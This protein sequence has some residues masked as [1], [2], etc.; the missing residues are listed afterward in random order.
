VAF[1]VLLAGPGVRGDSLMLLQSQAARR[2]A[3]VGE[4]QLARE[5]VPYR[6]MCA[7]AVAGDSVRLASAVRALVDLQLAG[8]PGAA[9]RQGAALDRLVAS[10]VSQVSDPWTRYFLAHDPAPALRRLRVPVLALN[11]SRDIQVTPRENL[12]GIERALEAGG[13]RDIT[14]QELPGLNHLFQACRTCTVD[15]YARLEETLSPAA[16]TMVSY[17]IRKRTER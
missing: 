9:P 11:G 1:V 2:A 15:E 5:A 14:V 8:S 17:W 7:A 12:A 4:E 3:G 10:T 13:N 16:L 6:D